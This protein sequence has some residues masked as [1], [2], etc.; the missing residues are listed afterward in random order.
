M[1]TSII[2]VWHRTM[3]SINFNVRLSTQK[4]TKLIPGTE[5]TAEELKKESL[6]EGFIVRFHFSWAGRTNA[7]TRRSRNTG[8]FD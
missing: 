4:Q 1:L 7:A 6:P 8:M 3:F 2:L 5:R